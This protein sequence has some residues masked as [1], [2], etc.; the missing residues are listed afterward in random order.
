MVN[1]AVGKTLVPRDQWR[2]FFDQLSM[3]HRGQLLTIQIIRP[4]FRDQDLI[5]NVPLLAIIY[6]RPGKGDNVMIEMGH[7]QVTYAHTIHTPTEVATEQNIHLM[8]WIVDATG[9]KTA[10]EIQQPALTLG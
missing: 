10:I 5:R 7:D 2:T 1:Q 4:A 9:T 3:A 6:D 8:M